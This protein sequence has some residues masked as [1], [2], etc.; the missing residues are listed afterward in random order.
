MI[1]LKGLSFILSSLLSYY[2]GVKVYFILLSVV[3]CKD[4][5]IFK[6]SYLAK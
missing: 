2:F 1:P 4:L 3:H 6:K 5:L